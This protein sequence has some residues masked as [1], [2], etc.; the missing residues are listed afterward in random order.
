MNRK[1]RLGFFAVLLA[2]GS[3]LA[4]RGLRDAAAWS[5]AEA[6]CRDGVVATDVTGLI[7]DIPVDHLAMRDAVECA[8]AAEAVANSRDTCF[9]RLATVVAHPDHDEWVPDPALTA[10][11]LEYEVRRGGGGGPARRL[12]EHVLATSN[13]PVPLASAVALLLAGTS[14]P[15]ALVVRVDAAIDPANSAARIVLS[16][17]FR[18]R[19]DG[20]AAEL[21]LGATPP[22]DPASRQDWFVAKASARATRAEADGAED[23]LDEWQAGGVDPDEVMAQRLFVLGREQL[24]SPRGIDEDEAFERGI[25]AAQRRGNGPNLRFLFGRAI[26]K[27][28]ISGKADEAIKLLGRARAAGAAPASMTPE[29]LRLSADA[30]QRETSGRVLVDVRRYALTVQ[31]MT[32]ASLWVAHGDDP[33]D[34]P[35]R[36]VDIGTPFPALVPLRYLVRDPDLAV[37][38]SGRVWPDGSTDGV[39]TRLIHVGAKAAAAA[40]AS[41]TPT[42]LLSRPADGRAR[43][44]TVLLDCGD[45]RISRL[46]IE[47]G[48]LPVIARLVSSGTTAV[49]RSSPAY[50]AEALD[51]MVYP[52]SALRI[53]LLGTFHK[54]GDELAG[55]ASVGSNPWSTVDQ[56]LPRRPNFFTTL[57]AGERTAVNLLFTLGGQIAGGP[58]NGEVSGPSGQRSVRPVGALSRS[59]SDDEGDRYPLLKGEI[60]IGP[61]AAEF[62]LLE[63]EASHGAIDVVVMRIEALDL[64]THQYFV[65]VFDEAAADEALKLHAAYRYIDERLGALASRLDADDTLVVM[66]D[67]G[68]ATGLKHDERA[69]WIV[70][71]PG[72]PVRRLPDTPNLRGVPAALAAL[73]GVQTD[74]PATGLH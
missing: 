60:H 69:M 10:A 41:T 43:L 71:G 25:A 3:G 13:D 12:A 17:V 65:E 45:W 57:G 14:D 55:L 39:T 33:V 35:Y 40:A 1:V 26:G 44:F 9:T 6:L 72:V 28:A 66:S 23:V 32:G 20:T 73:V 64:L 11:W 49:L 56:F 52:S 59:L 24:R 63:D 2:V 19:R 48:E 67:H 53:S 34:A 5:A 58:R 30:A 8:C 61:I 42:G 70:N 4:V 36:R 38:H 54:M 37:L 47:R 29:L 68:I 16:E 15:E 51:S 22:A 62:D 46:L 7:K 74:W 50:T 18:R 31:G 21:I 27:L